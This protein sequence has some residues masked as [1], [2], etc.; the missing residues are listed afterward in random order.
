MSANPHFPH[1]ASPITLG[2][3][4]V[5]NRLVFQPHFTALPTADGMP[6]P[7]LGLSR[8]ASA[9]RRRFNVTGIWRS[10]RKERTRHVL[11]AWDPRVVRSTPP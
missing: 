1:L 8:R 6:S 5:R 7:E 4:M 10:C 11:A 9:R 2:N 3:V